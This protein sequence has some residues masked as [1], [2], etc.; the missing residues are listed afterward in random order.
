M[1][2]V[3]KYTT[4][5][6]VSTFSRLLYICVYVPVSCSASSSLAPRT[7][8]FGEADIV[9]FEEMAPK[10]KNPPGLVEFPNISPKFPFN[11]G[12]GDLTLG[13]SPKVLQTWE[14]GSMCLWLIS[15]QSLFW[16]KRY[17]KSWEMALKAQNFP[18]SGEIPKIFGEIGGFPQYFSRILWHL[19]VFPQVLHCLYF[20]IVWVMSMFMPNLCSPSTLVLTDLTTVQH[21]KYCLQR[22]HSHG[23]A[24]LTY[25]NQNLWKTIRF[26][27]P[28]PPS[29]DA[30]KDLTLYLNTKEPT[31]I[32]CFTL[33]HHKH[34]RF[35]TERN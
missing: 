20:L 21:N 1:G 28:I 2:L 34:S 26:T 29:S 7:P 13:I 11:L 31:K 17:R 24:A 18:M 9:N 10:P 19:E 4:P 27:G 23:I 32:N 5:L 33:V 14:I 8:N 3:I 12:E 22:F 6:S 16:G 35:H 15:S 30:A 25:P